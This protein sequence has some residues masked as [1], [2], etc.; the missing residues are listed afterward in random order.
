MEESK[1]AKLPEGVSIDA[2]QVKPEDRPRRSGLEIPDFAVDAGLPTIY[3]PHYVN[4]ARTELSC[5][6][7]RPDGMAVKEENIPRDE[8]HPLY[9]DIRSQFTEQEIDHNTAREI[10]IQQAKMK[11]AELKETQENRERKRSELWAR[12]STYLDMDI[13]KNTRYKSLKRKLRQATN[14][15]EALAYGVAI[16]VKETDVDEE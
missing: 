7:L 9:R 8:K 6:L 4:N 5:L 3:Y 15:E 16:I 14:P 10:K 13:V 11:D 12:K 2:P 1:T